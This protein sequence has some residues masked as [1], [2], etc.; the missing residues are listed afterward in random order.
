[1]I[2]LISATGP[3]G[4]T[5]AWPRLEIQLV[6]AGASCLFLGFTAMVLSSQIGTRNLLLLSTYS[7]GLSWGVFCCALHRGGLKG[8][9][10]PVS[11]P[12]A[13]PNCNIHHI[14][15]DDSCPCSLKPNNQGFITGFPYN[16]ASPEPWGDSRNK[17]R[18]FL[19]VGKVL[20]P[21]LRKTC[22]SSMVLWVFSTLIAKLS[23]SWHPS[24]LGDRVSGSS[25][26]FAHSVYP[27]DPWADQIKLTNQWLPPSKT[28]HQ[29]VC[30]SP[31]FHSA[32]SCFQI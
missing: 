13:Q 10:G 25:F 24:R 32:L 5:Q 29:T 4:I 11:V 15:A 14:L 23:A 18:L 17:W 7:L 27:F 19:R 31:C 20:E 2:T 6:L 26:I 30:I 21:W 28:D 16:L 8:S 22:S 9:Q 12:Q 1:M 3:N